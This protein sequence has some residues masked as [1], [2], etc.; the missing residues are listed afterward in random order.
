MLMPA[1]PMMGLFF[2]FLLN[3]LGLDNTAHA[4]VIKPALIEISAN[5]QGQISIEIRASIEALINRD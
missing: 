3:A 5:T 1:K 2:I 4:D